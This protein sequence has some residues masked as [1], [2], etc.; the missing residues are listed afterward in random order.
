MFEWQVFVKGVQGLGFLN[1][2][3]INTPNKEIG[4]CQEQIE[5]IAL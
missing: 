1:C 5:L 2:S 3:V 4:V